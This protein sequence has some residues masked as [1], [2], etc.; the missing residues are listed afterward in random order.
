MY[1]HCPDDNGTFYNYGASFLDGY[2]YWSDRRNAPITTEKELE[3]ED[4]RTRSEYMYSYSPILRYQGNDTDHPNLSSVY[5]DRMWGW[6]YDKYRRCAKEAYGDAGQMGLENHSITQHE[7]LLRS[8]FDDETIVLVRLI[9]Y[10]NASNGYPCYRFDYY[11][12]K[13]KTDEMS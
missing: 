2:I 13:E 7:K 10:C 3:G 9:E 1:V 5:H 11:S 12:T 6:D 4:I 8:F